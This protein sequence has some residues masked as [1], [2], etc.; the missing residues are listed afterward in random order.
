MKGENRYL[1]KKGILMIKF[2]LLVLIVIG[3]IL[4]A[5]FCFIII[6]A[7]FND[8]SIGRILSTFGAIAGG[9]GYLML[10]S[11]AKQNVTSMLVENIIFFGPLGLIL[12]LLL[13]YSFSGKSK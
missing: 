10:C 5:G 4:C 1:K 2:I 8:S 11:W 13:G 9:V 7:I 6:N 12:L 3:I